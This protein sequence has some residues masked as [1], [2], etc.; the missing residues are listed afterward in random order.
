ME[1]IIGKNPNQQSLR[2]GLK[3][4]QNEKGEFVVE[5]ESI[6]NY[7]SNEINT[8]NN[9]Q[10]RVASESS[11]RMIVASK[12]VNESSELLKKSLHNLALQKIELENQCKKISG[13]VRESADKLGNGLLRVEKMADFNKLERYVDLLERAANAFNQLAELEKTGKLEKI[14]ASIR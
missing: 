14:A 6:N 5:T 1:K 13:S 10:N 8:N 12:I 2:M 3:E 9:Y 11:E 7:I 4:K